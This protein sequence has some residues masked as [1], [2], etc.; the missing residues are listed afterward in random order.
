MTTIIDALKTYLESYTGLTEE[1]PTWVNFMGPEPINYSIVPLPGDVIL[2]TYLNGATDRQFPFAFQSTESTADEL[3]RIKS[4]DFY[5]ALAAWFESQT[6]ADTLPTLDTGK[7]A[8]A[9]SARSWGFLYEQGVSDIGQYQ[10][11][12]VLEYEQKA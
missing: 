2:R 6:L 5:E 11:T 1:A 4:V 12:C 9:I 8:T 7:T 10:I 3:A